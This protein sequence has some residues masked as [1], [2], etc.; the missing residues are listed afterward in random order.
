MRCDGM[1]DH[2]GEGGGKVVRG[3]V[4]VVERYCGLYDGTCVVCRMVGML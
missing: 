2:S 4:W 1:V 3:W